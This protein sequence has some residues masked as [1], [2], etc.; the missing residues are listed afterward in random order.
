MGCAARGRHAVLC[1]FRTRELAASAAKF[2][3][4][5]PVLVKVLHRPCSARSSMFLDSKMPDAL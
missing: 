5:E 2:L 1:D 4:L 3:Q